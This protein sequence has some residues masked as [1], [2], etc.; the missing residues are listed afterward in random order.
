MSDLTLSS[1]DARWR[2][3][4]PHTR[5][6]ASTPEQHAHCRRQG[7]L[8]D[9]WYSGLPARWP[10]DAADDA[11]NQ[12]DYLRRANLLKDRLLGEL[13]GW[14]VC[15]PGYEPDLNA[16]LTR[17]EVFPA[18]ARLVPGEPGQCHTNTAALYLANRDRVRIATGYALSRDGIWRQHS[19]GM[20]LLPP[21][22][23][24]PLDDQSH[25]DSITRPRR[26]ER[27]RQ[28]RIV[29]ETTVRRVRYYGVVFSAAESDRFAD[30]NDF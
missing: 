15:L 30:N 16:L 4:L 17:G 28:H 24:V 13:G 9:T 6:G 19:W 1:L 5:V 26:P 25:A 18:A 10:T 2:H 3:H 20:L 23:L 12:D 21:A 11:A 8:A 27:S 22:P 14:C 29:L 7:W